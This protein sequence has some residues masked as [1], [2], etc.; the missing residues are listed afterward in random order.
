MDGLYSRN[1]IQLFE[2]VNTF[3]TAERE[4]LESE[5]YDIIANIGNNTVDIEGGYADSTW[6]LPNYNGLLD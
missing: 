1:P 4:Q 6:E 5:G 2:A 3:K